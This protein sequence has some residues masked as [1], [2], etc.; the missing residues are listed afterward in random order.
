MALPAERPRRW[1]RVCAFASVHA[2][3]RG[4]G[5]HH[6]HRTVATGGGGRGVCSGVLAVTVPSPR[7]RRA[8][9]LGAQFV[10]SAHV[11]HLSVHLFC[12][13]FI[14]LSPHLSF[15]FP[16]LYFGQK[17]VHPPH[18]PK[19]NVPWPIF[20]LWWSQSYDGKSTSF[21]YQKWKKV[22]KRGRRRSERDT[23]LIF[24]EGLRAKKRGLNAHFS[25]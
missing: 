12:Q 19:R 2:R 7:E 13:I 20:C 22:L 5:W 14:H 18:P 16:H 15:F 24:C 23:L 8:L 1:S 9:M 25:R 6:M 11:P 3:W 21:Q 17:R 4:P 10:F